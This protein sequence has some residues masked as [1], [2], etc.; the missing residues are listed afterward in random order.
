LHTRFAKLLLL[1]KHKTHKQILRLSSL[2]VGKHP[3]EIWLRIAKRNIAR[4]RVVKHM[5]LLKHGSDVP[6]HVAII[7]GLQIDI[8]KKDRTFGRLEQR[9]NQFDESR[10]PAATAAHESHHP[11]RG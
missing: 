2:C 10:F 1:T 8:V 7:Q 6:A 11:P 4:D 3:I 9:S 5:I